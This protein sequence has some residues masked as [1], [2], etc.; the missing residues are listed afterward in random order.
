MLPSVNRGVLEAEYVISP[1]G[2]DIPPPKADFSAPPPYE[3]VT[4]LPTY[5]EVQREKHLEG[6]SIPVPIPPIS[7]VSLLLWI[8]GMNC[9]NLNV[10]PTG[11]HPPTHR[12]LAIDADQDDTDTSLLGTDFMFY[13]AFFGGH[14]KWTILKLFKIIG[15]QLHLFLTGSDFC[16]SCVFVTQLLHDMELYQVLDCH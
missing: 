8:D 14:L 13:T 5:E 3:A 11:F 2:D 1:A 7:H 6:S 12:V 4:K 15:F 9:L 10:Q 16:Y